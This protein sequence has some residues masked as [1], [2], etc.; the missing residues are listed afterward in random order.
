MKI[1]D[2]YWTSRCNILVIECE[3]GFDF[4]HRADKW[5]VKC[6]KCGKTD[7]LQRIRDDGAI[8]LR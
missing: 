3:C 7:N 1:V 6:S 4:A 2:A 5:E 8:S